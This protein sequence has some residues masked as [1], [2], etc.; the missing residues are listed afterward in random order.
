MVLLSRS[1]RT[2]KNGQSTARKHTSREEMLPY[3]RRSDGG[4]LFRFNSEHKAACTSTAGIQVIKRLFITND[5]RKYFQWIALV[6]WII[7]SVGLHLDRGSILSPNIYV[8]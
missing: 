8:P 5:L 6:W 3:R 2:E 1:I 4:K 7:I